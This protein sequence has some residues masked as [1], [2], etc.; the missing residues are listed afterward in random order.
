VVL[1]FHFYDPFSSRTNAPLVDGWAFFQAMV[2]PGSIPGWKE[3]LARRTCERGRC[4]LEKHGP[5]YW[6]KDALRK[7]LSPVFAVRRGRQIYCGEFGATKRAP[8][9]PVWLS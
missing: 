5:V 9:P 2:Y 3:D 8:G 4:L 7:L 6:D 1:S